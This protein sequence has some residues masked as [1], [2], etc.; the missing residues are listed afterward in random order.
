[1]K[2][3]QTINVFKD[4]LNLEEKKVEL[5]YAIASLLTYILSNYRGRARLDNL[6][7]IGTSAAIFNQSITSL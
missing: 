1:M 7:E 6:K 5:Q 2:L 3:Q 4:G